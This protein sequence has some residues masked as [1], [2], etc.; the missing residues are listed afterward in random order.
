[1]IPYLDLQKIND[2][3]EPQLSEE[4]V[5]VTRSGWYLQGEENKRFEQK[6]AAYCNTNYCV[7]TGNG[8]DALTLI[9]MAYIEMGLAQ[10]GDDIIVPANTYIAT[11][12]SVLR[13]GLKPVLCEPSPQTYNINPELIESIITSRTKAIIAVHLYGQC[14]DMEA[15]SQI[16]K[17]HGIKVIEDVAQAPGAIY[18]GKR[19][20]SLGDAAAF[21]FYPAKNL[22]ALGDGGAVTTNDKHL[23]ELVRMIGNYGSSIKYIHP[24]K[25]INS[26]LDEI[27]AAVLSLKLK[28]LDQGNNRRREIAK[29][30]L[31]WIDHPFIVLPKVD[32]FEKHVFH[33]FPVFSPRRDILQAWLADKGIH[34]QIHYPVPPHL[35]QALK[36]YGNFHLPITEQ[37]HREE[38]SLPISPLLTEEE[39]WHIIK[40]INSFK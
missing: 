1:M 15:I 5:R 20:G 18:G 25:G 4:V 2:A 39:V 19:T 11:I 40:A 10:E 38:L 13:A 31:K 24:Y 29:L 22:G 17:K 33:I 32:D 12:L 14:A 34:T 35:Q 26:R 9:L 27:Q 6:F 8:L 21:S 37:I 30:Y 16:A 23:A 7:G 36:E 3:F 28:R